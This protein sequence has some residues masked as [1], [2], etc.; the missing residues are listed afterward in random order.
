MAQIKVGDTDWGIGILVAESE[1]GAYQP[2]AAVTTISEARE[3]AASD[4]HRRT[5]DINHGEDSM[6]PFRYR[7]WARASSGEYAIVTEIESI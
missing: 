7:V 6:C 4:M 3:I 1:E 2:V 5:H